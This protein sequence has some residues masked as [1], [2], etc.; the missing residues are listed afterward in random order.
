MTT[1]LNPSVRALLFTRLCRGWKRF[2]KAERGAVAV[3]FA[4]TS[5]IW[6]GGL[7]FGAEVGYWY[8][9]EQRV[10]SVAETI[11]LG[12][13]ARLQSH[14]SKNELENIA[15]SMLTQENRYQA[16]RFQVTNIEA[17]EIGSEVKDGSTV[18]VTVEYPLR[19]Y[20][21]SFFLPENFNVTKTARAEMLKGSEGC[22]LGLANAGHSTVSFHE[23]TSTIQNCEV[24]ANSNGKAIDAT[25]SGNLVADC[26]RSAGSYIRREKITVSCTNSR[27]PIS[28]AGKAADPLALLPQPNLLGIDCGTT[29]NVTITA[30]EQLPKKASLA[31]GTGVRVFCH[32]VVFDENLDLPAGLYVFKKGVENKRSITV[33]AEGSTFYFMDY[34]VPFFNTGTLKITAPTTGTYAGI[35]MFSLDTLPFGTSAILREAIFEGALYFPRGRVNVIMNSSFDKCVQ[36]IA[37]T[38]LISG[39]WTSTKGPCSSKF[40]TNP[41]LSPNAKSVL[42][43]ATS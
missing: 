30:V 26:V 2:S 35:A 29:A 33:K 22:V 7:A 5:P 19:R 1:P 43:D 37:D 23:G 9:I 17:S 24:L 8:Y 13:A 41:I 36:I 42:V 31:D 4:Y 11:A 15:N 39:T 16:H 40:G 12:T 18:T 34:S 20:F 14:P 6:L 3:L 28:W 10:E 32:K 21:T 27:V 25:L 38:V